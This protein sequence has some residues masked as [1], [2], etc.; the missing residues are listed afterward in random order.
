M[1][2]TRPIPPEAMPVV[3]VLRR[4]VPRP[5]ELPKPLSYIS[6]GSLRWSV[7]RDGVCVLCCPEGLHRESSH[8]IPETRR[9]FAGG[10]C[11][12][13]SVQAFEDWWDEQESAAEAVEA[14]WPMKE[15]VHE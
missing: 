5:A 10:K 14:V 12:S 13:K 6:D 15:A 8:C 4:D 9:E 7:E 2:L 3:E 11:S 1:P